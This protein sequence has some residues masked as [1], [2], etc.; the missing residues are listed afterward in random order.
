[1]ES[2]TRVGFG[3]SSAHPRP[4]TFRTTSIAARFSS[5]YPNAL[6]SPMQVTTP[7]WRQIYTSDIRKDMYNESSRGTP[8]FGVLLPITSRGTSREVLQAN[9]TRLGA[10]LRATV[11]S[12]ADTLRV[13]VG[14]DKDDPSLGWLPFSPVKTSSG[15]FSVYI[16]DK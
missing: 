5:R 2:S 9:L 10:S 16:P 8:L 4:L 1:M 11:E 13:F 3:Q 15:S 7:N 12:P 14:V 6:C